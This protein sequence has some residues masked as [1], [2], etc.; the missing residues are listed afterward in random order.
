MKIRKNFRVD[1]DLLKHVEKQPVVK[2]KGLTWYVEYALKKI[3]KYKES[4][5]V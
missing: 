3:S 4:E 1:E 2:K 5:L